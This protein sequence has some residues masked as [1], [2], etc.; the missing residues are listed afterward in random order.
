MFGADGNTFTV[1][2]RTWGELDNILENSQLAC[3]SGLRMV[4]LIL[5]KEDV[6]RGPLSVLMGEEKQRTQSSKHQSG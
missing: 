2:A 3:G 1:C 6:P 4:E 5:D